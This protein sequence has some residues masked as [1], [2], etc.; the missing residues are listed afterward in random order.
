MCN[1]WKS[2]YFSSIKGSMKRS[3]SIFSDEATVPVDC[4]ASRIWYKPLPEE[5][6]LELIGRYKHLTAFHCI[7][8]ISRRGPSQLFVFNGKLNGPGFQEA[9]DLF[10]LPFIEEK[11]PDFHI[12]HMDNAPISRNRNNKRLFR[13]E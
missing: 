12:L 8:A 3:H 13:R 4:N 2:G 5:T 9:C 10:L 1:I 7:G 6:R 11:Y